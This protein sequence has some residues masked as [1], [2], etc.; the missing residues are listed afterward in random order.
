[1]GPSGEPPYP[2]RIGVLMVVCVLALGGLFM[3]GTRLLQPAS[4]SAESLAPTETAIAVAVATAGAAVPTHAPTLQP[5]AP[6][7]APPS[8]GQMQPTSPPAAVQP[9]TAR[10]APTIAATTAATVR[11][12]EP[13]TAVPTPVVSPVDPATDQEVSDA[14]LHYFDVRGQALLSNDPTG[15]DEVADGPPLQGLTQ[16][17]AAHQA[18]G[19]ALE[20][21]VVHHF[22]VVHIDGD[23]DGEV[24]VVD[25]YKDLSY[26]VDATTH[27]PLPGQS[28]PDT[29]ADAP[30]VDVIYHLNK[31]DGVWKVVG[32]EIN[33][34]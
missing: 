31:I 32:G 29:E 5:A 8:L 26:W 20:T 6:A 34:S 13:A 30:E 7:T 14:Y 18:E 3:G 28:I 2:W 33:D 27:N 11:P 16:N 15:L 22:N 25:H 12:T 17:I 1:M 21:D 19:K 23:P 4:Q 10:S 9:T 24:S